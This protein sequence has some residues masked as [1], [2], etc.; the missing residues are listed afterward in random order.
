MVVSIGT[1]S[2][3]CS[4]T[5]GGFQDSGSLGVAVERTAGVFHN[6]QPHGRRL[7]VQA[8]GNQV[9]FVDADSREVLRVAES[10]DL[11]LSAVYLPGG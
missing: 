8:S 10:L 9:S 7:L 3:Q 6:G 2:F 1:P 4:Q 11:S 5:P